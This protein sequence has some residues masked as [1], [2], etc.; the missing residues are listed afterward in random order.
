MSNIN[1]QHFIE[2]LKEEIKEHIIRDTEKRVV[3]EVIEIIDGRDFLKARVDNEL[4]VSE[5]CEH[6][7]EELRKKYGVK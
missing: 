6:I 5:A 7:I 3:D 1:Y 4:T 2:E